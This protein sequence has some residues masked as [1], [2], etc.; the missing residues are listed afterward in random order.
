M[1]QIDEDYAPEDLLIPQELVL[2]MSDFTLFVEVSTQPDLLKNRSR[3]E[4]T[5]A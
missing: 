5:N 2:R 3:P 4:H 1:M